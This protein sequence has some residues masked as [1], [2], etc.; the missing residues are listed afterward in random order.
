M[1][2]A[3]SVMSEG[4][5]PKFNEPALSLAALRIF[6]QI[7]DI[8]SF[9]ASLNCVFEYLTKAIKVAFTGAC[10]AKAIT[11]FEHLKAIDSITE[12]TECVSIVTPLVVPVANRS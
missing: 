6:S 12:R 5:I 4:V 10:Y 7:A 9:L 2:E 11:A 3:R 8:S 1:A